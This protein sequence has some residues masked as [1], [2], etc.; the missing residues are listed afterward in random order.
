ME[1]LR[2]VT[3]IVTST[4]YLQILQV[5][6]DRGHNGHVVFVNKTNPC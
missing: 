1:N 2:M 5:L 4:T 3:T 6:L